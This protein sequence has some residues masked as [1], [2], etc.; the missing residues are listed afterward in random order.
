METRKE[1]I[2]KSSLLLT[3]SLIGI[4]ACWSKSNDLLS[5]STPKIWSALIHLS[6]NMWEDHDRLK[7]DPDPL[8]KW[9]C[10]DKNIRL[11][12]T[13]WRDTLQ[14]MKT[15]GL[16]MVVIDV[17][18]AIQFESHPE[19]AINGAWSKE[20]LRKE[21]AYIR[22]LGIEPIPKLNFSAGHDAWLKEYSHMLS[23]PR[24]YEVCRHII[25]ETIDLFDNPRF[26]HLGYDEENYQDQITYD[27][28]AIRQNDIWWKD[29]HFFV[30]T[31]EKFGSQAWIWSDFFWR[32]PDQF[33]KKMPK[34][35]IQSNWYYGQDFNPSTNPYVDAYIKINEAGYKQIPTGGYF[36]GSVHGR[37]E[38][39]DNIDATVD[40]S[41]K[42][43]NDN[44][45]LGF[46]QTNWKPTV[47]L[48]RNDIL[49]SINRTGL[50]ISKW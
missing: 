35:V 26:F 18:D 45:L 25:Q 21:L 40:F 48:H 2:K 30:D 37:K 7:D 19:L 12:E 31:V 34:S 6:F 9:R 20:K 16:N 36:S 27:Y 13:L 24:Y 42:Y 49:E 44:L 11:S 46:M 47:D 41:K 39:K 29:F 10:F 14:L 17:G 28:I 50:A 1:F 15:R 3:S 8:V 5:T 23:T 4:N 33:L 32:H 22:S 38:F 43:L